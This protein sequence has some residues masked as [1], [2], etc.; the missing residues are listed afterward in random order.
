VGDATVDPARARAAHDDEERTVVLA[1]QVE[2][3]VRLERV[4]PAGED[5]V[6]ALDRPSLVLGRGHGCDVK[7]R[8]PTASREH[9]RIFFQNGRWTIASLERK[10]FYVDGT[11][12]AGGEVPLA[13]GMRLKLGDDEFVVVDTA[14]GT[15][16]ARAG[17]GP[18]ARM[19]SFVRGL[20][21]RRG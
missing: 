3:T 2:T 15:V 7:L 10:T 16:P 14:G 1:R 18:W 11:R 17:G 6:I 5:E 20:M 9:A 12:H 4:A 13:G 19:V 8:T 21:G